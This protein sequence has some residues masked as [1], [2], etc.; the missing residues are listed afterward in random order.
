MEVRDMKTGI[1]GRKP[2]DVCGCAILEQRELGLQEV[3][4]HSCGS[5]LSACSCAGA[6]RAREDSGR[7]ERIDCSRVGV[8]V[9]DS[10]G[11]ACEA[12]CACRC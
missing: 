7:N 9:W 6:D 3:V 4:C 2:S 5:A 10:V 8:I 1:N 11:E 12:D